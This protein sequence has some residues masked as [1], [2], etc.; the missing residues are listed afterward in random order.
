MDGSYAVL[1]EELSHL[2]HTLDVD[3]IAQMVDKLLLDRF[4]QSMKG[5]VK[6]LTDDNPNGAFWGDYTSMVSI[7]LSF[8]R[9]QRD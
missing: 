9:A 4:Q 5:F 2:S 6:L 8:V 7:M 1:K 3:H